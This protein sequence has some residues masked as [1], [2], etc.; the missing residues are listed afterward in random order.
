MQGSKGDRETARRELAKI[1]ARL[2]VAPKPT[3]DDAPAWLGEIEGMRDFF[4]SAAHVWDRVFGPEEG[5]R[6]YPEVAAQIEP[7]QDAVSILV[8]GCGTGLELPDLFA[9]APNARLTG[10]D[11]AP[12]MLAELRRKFAAQSAQIELIEG[13]YLDV[14]LGQQRFDYAIATLTAHHL[15]PTS[16]LS[17]YRRIREALVLGG[18]YIEGDQSTDAAGEAETLRWYD[19]YIAKLPGGEQA[20][21]NYD[22]TLSPETR[23]RLLQEAGLQDV[24]LSWHESEAGLAV[25]TA[26]AESWS[27]RPSAPQPPGSPSI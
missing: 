11:V 10:I 23:R 12:G 14:P 1:R 3:I 19:A 16:K 8:L 18:R 17:L 2:P 9:R 21:W 4:D 24:Q 13:S 15:S 26:S 6:L 7:T 20:R 27:T 5:D 22:V 25:F